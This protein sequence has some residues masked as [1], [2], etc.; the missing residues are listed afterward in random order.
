M[1]AAEDPPPDWTCSRCGTNNARRRDSCK[2]CKTVG[3]EL[4]RHAEELLGS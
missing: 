3:P 1:A 4:K 2:E